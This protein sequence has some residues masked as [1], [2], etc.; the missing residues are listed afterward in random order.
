MRAGAPAREPEGVD[1][2]SPVV[3][4]RMT[5]ISVP[6]LRDYGDR[7]WLPPQEVDPSTRRRLHH[8]RQVD[9]AVLLRALLVTGMRASAAADAVLTQDRAAVLD[10]LGGVTSAVAAARERLPV[11]GKQ[12][13]RSVF[14]DAESL[15]EP[16]DAR[17][18]R[19][20]WGD[21]AH[22]VP[23]E[24]AHLDPLERLRWARRRLAQES[25]LALEDLPRAT[26]REE[27]LPDGPV[28]LVEVGPGCAHPEPGP[29]PARAVQPPWPPSEPVPAGFRVADVASAQMA[30]LDL[31]PRDWSAQ[32]SVD[33]ELAV[34]GAWATPGALWMDGMLFWDALLSRACLGV[35]LR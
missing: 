11:P 18:P 33:E 6:R 15:I 17:T 8:P 28:V 14:W 35:V 31:H 30:V 10:H 9:D 34:I 25:G 24:A 21:P 7:G 3:F 12:G 20:R 32:P 5:G 27:G 23:V 13:V 4:S 19:R 22:D 1:L 29:R 26:D 16:Y 2:L